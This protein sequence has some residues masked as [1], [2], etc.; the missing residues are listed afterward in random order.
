MKQILAVLAAAA[1]AA[2]CSGLA[3][4]RTLPIHPWVA[5][6][7]PGLVRSVKAPAWERGHPSSGEWIAV[8]DAPLER[9]P[10]IG[11]WP[12]SPLPSPP[13]RVPVRRSVWPHDAAY[14]AVSREE[15]RIETGWIPLAKIHP[16]EVRCG[17]LE[18]GRGRT[19]SARLA[20]RVRARGDG[21]VVETWWEVRDAE[22]C[23]LSPAARHRT[24]AFLLDLWAAT[25]HGSSVTSHHLPR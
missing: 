20:G 12:P 4:H 6:P 15:V 23:R 3:S 2:G 11:P 16:A 9:L 7:T 25:E 5:P 24:R 8:R 14:S 19:P 10:F 21:A 18:R 1:M 13:G 17:E 22:E